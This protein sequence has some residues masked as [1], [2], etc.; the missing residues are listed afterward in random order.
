[1]EELFLPEQPPADAWADGISIRVRMGNSQFKPT[2][3]PG[4]YWQGMLTNCSREIP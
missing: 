1:M 4:D 3:A 2:E